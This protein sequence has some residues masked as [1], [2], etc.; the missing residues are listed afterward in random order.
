[1]K[2][3]VLIL[4]ALAMTLSLPAQKKEINEA[5]TCLKTNK[6]LDKA[7]KLM[8]SVIAMPGQEHVVENHVLLV[9]ILKKQYENS[10]EK[11]Y[12]RQLK[13]TASVFP[14][15]QRV[16]Y[17]CETLDSVEMMPDKKGR[18]NIKMRGKNSVYLNTVRPNLF[19]GGLFFVRKKN[20]K[21]ALDCF[22]T[23]IDSHRQPLFSRMEYEVND[24]LFAQASYW[25]LM[26]SSRLK[27]FES[28]RKYEADAL[29]YKDRAHIT[30]AL[31]Y[32]EYMEHGDTVSAVRYLSQGFK[33]YSEHT[34]FFPRL[35]DYYSSRNQMDT[36]RSIVSIA[37]EREPGNLFYRLARNT[38]QLTCGDYDDCIA[39]G[40]SLIHSNDKMA[41]AYFNVGSSYFN[42]AL[43]RESKG[44]EDRQK[45]KEVNA[46]YE[47][48]MPYLE[49][50]RRQR[51]RAMLKWVPMLYSVY[52]NLNKGEQFDEMD[53][54]MKSEKYNKLLKKG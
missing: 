15:L 21:D 48:A 35:V 31:L 23:Y 1:M 6:N 13:D 22:E 8:R 44:R 42:K 2:K 27:D 30:L 14:L 24:T 17:A 34:F 53:S 10:N 33:D 37:I 49:E 26:A 43:Q 19:N 12:L 46:L 28:I 39:L 47:K 51:P 25:A 16:F 40:D 36:V 52:L 38:V 3:I 11:M 41:E 50:Y 45:R 20:Y 29:K 9:D 54:L 18:V 7:E 4:L 5:K 32:D